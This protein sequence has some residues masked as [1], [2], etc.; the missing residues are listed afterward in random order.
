M[1]SPIT[2]IRSWRDTWAAQTEYRQLDRAIHRPLDELAVTGDPQRRAE[3]LADCAQITLRMAEVYPT[4]FGLDPLPDEPGRDLADSM[5]YSGRLYGLLAQVEESV[6]RGR[7]T[8]PSGTSPLVTAARPVL[9]RMATEPALV[10]RASMLAE[11]YDVVEPV[12]GG[13]AAELLA[14]LPSPGWLGWE[15][16]RERGDWWV[17]LPVTPPGLWCAARTAVVARLRARL[18]GLRGLW[19][20][21]S[22]ASTEQI[23]RVRAG[24]AY[25][26][27]RRYGRG[28]DCPRCGTDGAQPPVGDSVT[29]TARRG[30]MRCEH[31]LGV[32]LVDGHPDPA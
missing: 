21:I 26:A 5:R 19:R 13:Q 28:T 24:A 14:C 23:A 30:F 32:G 27:C 18:Q 17:E 22:R 29:E 2:L 6:A 4:A 11:L 9:E 3:L 7:S 1:N 31:C 16:L 15:T 8:L 12:V 10:V 25:A 20:W